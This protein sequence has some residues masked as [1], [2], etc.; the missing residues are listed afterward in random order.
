VEVVEALLRTA[1]FRDLLPQDV[2]ELLPQ[3]RRV[4][5]SRGETVWNEGDPSTALYVVVEGQLKAYRVGRDGSEL[6]LEVVSSGE[7]T[8]E[9]GLFHPSGLRQVSVAAMQATRCLTVPRDA[10][11]AFM[12]KHPPVMLRMLESLSELTVRAA[13]SFY[14]VAFDDI[15]RRVARTLLQLC[16]EHA[17]QTAF[18]HRICLKLSQ[19][20]LAAMV[21]ASRENVNRALAL[22]LACG[23]VSQKD[24]YFFVHDRRAL[25]K[26]A[27]ELID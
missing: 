22:F 18:G 7:V 14:D 9:P 23:A 19:A 6:I 17:E 15:R 20:T 8:G 26:V 5:F 13:Y 3:V 25:E 2:R 21:A 16:D 11:V 1:I 10:L 12:T 24:G 4:T 27:L